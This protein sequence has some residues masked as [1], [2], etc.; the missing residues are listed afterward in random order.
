M[1]NS[2]QD[3]RGPDLNSD[4]MTSLVGATLHEEVK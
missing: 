1:P 2:D 4:R 3:N